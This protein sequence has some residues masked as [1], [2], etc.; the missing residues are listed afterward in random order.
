MASPTAFRTPSTV[1]SLEA[2]AEE[3]AAREA[4]GGRDV[5]DGGLVEPALGEQLEGGLGDLRAYRVAGAP[6]KVGRW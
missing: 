3:A 4:S 2:I 1:S 5:V 6:A